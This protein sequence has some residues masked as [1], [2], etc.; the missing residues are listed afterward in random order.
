MA[1]KFGEEIVRFISGW[2]V[3]LMK[4]CASG[5]ALSQDELGS[6]PAADESQEFH[7]NQLI[8][9][10]NTHLINYIFICLILIT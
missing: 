3:P 9:I 4:V 1:L 10:L 7:W 6:V 2:I 5:K 8:Y